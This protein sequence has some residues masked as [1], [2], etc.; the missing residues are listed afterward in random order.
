MTAQGN[1]RRIFQTAIERGNIVMAEA[2]A[3]ELGR[4]ITLHEAL[5]LTALV[6]EKDPKRRSRFRVRWLRWLLKDRRS[7]GACVGRPLRVDRLRQEGVDP[8]EDFGD[9]DALRV[10]D[11]SELTFV[12]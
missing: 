6:A 7:S 11:A 4:I 10:A 3:R 8:V 12:T 5:Q 9:V 1:P 2:A